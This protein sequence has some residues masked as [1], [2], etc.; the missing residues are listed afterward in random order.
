MCS[1]NYW[2]HLGFLCAALNPTQGQMCLQRPARGRQAQEVLVFLWQMQQVLGLGCTWCWWEDP[3]N[4]WAAGT[5]GTSFASVPLMLQHCGV[6]GRHLYHEHWSLHCTAAG[7][8]QALMPWALQPMSSCMCARAGTCAAVLRSTGRDWT[9]AKGFGATVTCTGFQ[10]VLHTLWPSHVVS[11][12]S[13]AALW[14]HVVEVTVIKSW[15]WLWLMGSGPHCGLGATAAAATAA[16]SHAV[17]HTAVL[18]QQGQVPGR[19]RQWCWCCRSQ[20]LVT[21]MWKQKVEAVPLC[22]YLPRAGQP[23]GHKSWGCLC[24]ISP[25][26]AVVRCSFRIYLSLWIMNVARSGHPHSS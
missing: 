13:Q 22:C 10:L 15:A 8:A 16:E 25:P 12:R 20:T 9:V 21:E 2:H 23:C 14:A 7:Q 17:P 19:C 6:R 11:T 4:M 24:H 26:V 18:G 1:C 3:G 5:D